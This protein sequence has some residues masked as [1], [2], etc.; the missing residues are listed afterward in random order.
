MT[1][2]FRCFGGKAAKTTEKIVSSALPE[3]ALNVVE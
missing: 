2:F 3:P 1:I